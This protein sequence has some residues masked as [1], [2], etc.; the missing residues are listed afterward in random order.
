MEAFLKTGKLG[1][2]SKAADGTGKSDGTKS[3]RKDYPVPWVE[4]YRPRSI[5]DVV[6]QEEVVAVLAR[7]LQGADLPNLLFYGPPGTGKTSTILAAARQLFGDGYKQRIL[8]LNAS[9]ER[10]ISVIREKVK[11]F[12]QLTVSST[13]PDGQPC[14]PFKLIILDEADAMTVAAQSALRRTM[15]KETKSTRFC[16][17]CNYLTRIIPPITSRCSKFRFKP[18]NE[19]MILGRLDKIC[20]EEG[21][22]FESGVLKTLIKISEGDMRRAITSLQSCHR[23]KGKDHV[24][25]VEDVEEI[26]GFVPMEWIEK[27]Y[28]ACLTG[29]YDKVDSVI[30]ESCRNGLPAARI[31]DQFFHFTLDNTDLNDEQKAKIFVKISECN[32]RLMDGGNEYLQL[33]DLGTAIM[34]IV[35]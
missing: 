20:G 19:D 27:L 22:K 9:D 34:R 7:I 25:T 23:L 18:L 31:I 29:N 32:F 8:E 26:S 35:T 13:L 21:V 5:T 30:E 15:E 2:S 24:L 11:K 16:L 4:K 6:Q 14:P 17:L 33:M 12:S 10:G 3:K 28:S 1:K